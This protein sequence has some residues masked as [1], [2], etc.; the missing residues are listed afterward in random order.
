[1]CTYEPDAAQNQTDYFILTFTVRRPFHRKD[2]EWRGIWKYRA[3]FCF[4]QL[5]VQSLAKERKQPPVFILQQ[6]IFYNIS[7][8]YLWLRIIR[9]S[10]Q[11]VQCMS[12][13][14]KIFFNNI[15]H[16]YSAAILKKS[17]LWVRFC[18]IWLWPLIAIM[19][20]SAERCTLQLYCTSLRKKV[21]QMKF[22]QDTK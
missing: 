17:S 1:M 22:V 15:N 11:G 8:Q 12:F 14:S 9:R 18:L 16:G 20:K 3:T 21:N 13:P 7:I 2:F 10:D 19:K 6:F 5:C 4:Y